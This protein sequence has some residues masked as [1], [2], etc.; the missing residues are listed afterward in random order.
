[1]LPWVGS[2]TA[3]MG[4]ASVL[5][6]I[7]F[8]VGVTLGI[9]EFGVLGYL[10]NICP[11]LGL[12]AFMAI[13]IVP[14]LWLIEFASLLIKHVILAMRLVA[15]M[16]AGHLVLLGIMGLAISTQAYTMG[17]VQWGSMAVVSILITTALSVLELFVAF[18]Q[19]AIFTFL[20][21]LFIHS[22]KHHH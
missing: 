18:L 2:P 10:K 19:A 6:L 12:P 5:A 1:M 17:S 9:K 21:A 15:N 22:A 8:V 3:A 14:M 11:S 7:I 20:S 13:V 4:M 16:V